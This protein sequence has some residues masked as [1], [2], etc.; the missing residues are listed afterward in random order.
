MMRSTRVLCLQCVLGTCLAISACTTAPP[1]AIESP[2]PPVTKVWPRLAQR[3]HGVQAL[4]ALCRGDPC[5][6]PTPKTLGPAS[7]D[8]GRAI[9]DS[10][11]IAP[12][13]LLD[14]LAPGEQ[15]QMHAHPTVPPV[16]EPPRTQ[17]PSVPP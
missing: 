2:A 7:K 3:G 11:P 12:I 14:S 4:F 8:L 17:I 15:V 6:Q 13:L 10:A 9:P 1:A 5:P 16:E